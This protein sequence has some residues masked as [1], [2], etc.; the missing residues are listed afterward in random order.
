M[1]YSVLCT[2]I[3]SPER[4]LLETARELGVA[5]VCYS[6]LAN[7]LLTGCLN[8][9]ADADNL[10]IRRRVLPWLKDEFL[11]KN[12]E[13]LSQITAIAKSK[14]ITTPQLA[15]AWLLAQGVDIFPIPGSSKIQRLEENLGSIFVDLSE[16]EEKM[17]RHLGEKVVGG[18]FQETTGYAFADTPALEE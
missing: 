1:E 16:E 3:E 4:R 13:I 8:S 17:I 10:G 12:I 9:M 7:G 6:P 5:V 15:L 2:E 11:E 14:N 18:R